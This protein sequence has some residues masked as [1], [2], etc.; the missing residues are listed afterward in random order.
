MSVFRQTADAASQ[1]ITD[2]NLGDYTGVASP[3]PLGNYQRGVNNSVPGSNAVQMT[4]TQ[5]GVVINSTTVSVTWPWMNSQ[6]KYK[7]NSLVDN[8]HPWEYD[9]S[10]LNVSFKMK[11]PWASTG[12]ASIAY[13]GCGLVVA[14]SNNKVISLGQIVFDTRG[15]IYISRDRYVGLESAGRGMA[16]GVATASSRFLDLLPGSHTASSSTWDEWQYYG[17]SIGRTEFL[18]AIN[19]LNNRF[20]DEDFSTDVTD[21]RLLLA[22]VSGEVNTTNSGY[23]A[24]GI[25]E[26]TI[27]QSGVPTPEPGMLVL[28]LCGAPGLVL[29]LWRR[30]RRS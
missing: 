21:Y 20:Q 5:A 24:W 25:D 22:A 10:A 17:F 2:W 6:I 11:L 29:F 3:D 4:G 12:G 14:D 19:D 9:D 16:G 26:W 13:A 30:C 28:L 8:I 1:T 23:M 18:N 15:G 27:W 7:W